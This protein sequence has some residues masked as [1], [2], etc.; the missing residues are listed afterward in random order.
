MVGLIALALLFGLRLTRTSLV[1][2]ALLVVFNFGGMISVMQMADVKK[3][4][5]YIAVSLFL[6]FTSVFFAAAIEGDYR[7][8]K[9]IFNA[10]L[11]VGVLSS[12]LGIAGYLGLFRVQ[13][14]SRATGV[15]R[16]HFR[17]PTSMGPS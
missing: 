11:L 8:L 13:K 6:A 17:T 1:L 5:L 7:R 9:T 15:R 16:A 3:A 4:P 12:V 14:S 10:Y 2:L